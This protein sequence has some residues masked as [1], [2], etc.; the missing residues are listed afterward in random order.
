MY[1]DVYLLSTWDGHVRVSPLK[2][3]SALLRLCSY[4]FRGKQGD[5]LTG[6]RPRR[7]EERRKEVG[8]QSC[9][10]EGEA[11]DMVFYGACVYSPCVSQS[12]IAA[13]FFRRRRSVLHGVFNS[14]CVYFTC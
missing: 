4:D 10:E 14:V 2:R 7:V 5:M 1:S 3:C 13:D 8:L 11:Y 12:C 9:S 6:L